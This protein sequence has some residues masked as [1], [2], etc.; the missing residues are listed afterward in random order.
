MALTIA[1]IRRGETS[2]AAPDETNICTAPN[3]VEVVLHFGPSRRCGQGE[4]K[5][6]GGGGQRKLNR[7]IPSP[8]L[9]DV[10]LCAGTVGFRGIPAMAD[11]QFQLAD[12]PLF[13]DPYTGP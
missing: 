7:A 4:R 3:Q 1:D 11:G 12:Q 5:G 8:H 10:R 9:R 2:I 6:E 13:R